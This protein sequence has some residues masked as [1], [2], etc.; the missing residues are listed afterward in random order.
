LEGHDGRID[1]VTVAGVPYYRALFGG[2]SASGAQG[3]CA[4]LKAAAQD[5]FVR[6]H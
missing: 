4:A 6:P 2:F 3:A 5:C 1:A